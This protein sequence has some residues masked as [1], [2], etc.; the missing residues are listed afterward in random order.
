MLPQ[1]LHSTIALP[2]T[3]LSTHKP[4]L[5]FIMRASAHPQAGTLH[6]KAGGDYVAHYSRYYEKVNE[7]LQLFLL[8]TKYVSFCT[9]ATGRA[10]S[11]E[12]RKWIRA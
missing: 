9:A 5:Y 11:P 10:A 3:S 7:I 2:K 4:L 12:E 1:I 6:K 8:P